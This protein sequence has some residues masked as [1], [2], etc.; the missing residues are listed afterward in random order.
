MNAGVGSRGSPTP[1]SITSIPRARASARHVVEPRER[2]LLE[3]REDRRELHGDSVSDRAP[4]RGIVARVR[5]TIRP[6]REDELAEWLPSGPPTGAR[7]ARSR[8]TTCASTRRPAAA[9]RAG[10]SGPERRWASRDGSP[11]D[12]DANDDHNAGVASGA[13]ATVR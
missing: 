4:P 5:V 11:T 13:T 3:P 12:A 9:A 6:L 7:E 8:C 10:R 1:K 2:I